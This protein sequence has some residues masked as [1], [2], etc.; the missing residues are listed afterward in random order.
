MPS[1]VTFDLEIAPGRYTESLTSVMGP[2]FPL[3]LE[4]APG[5]YNDSLTSVMGPKFPLGVGEFY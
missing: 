5:R 2:K 4:I 1:S 3:G